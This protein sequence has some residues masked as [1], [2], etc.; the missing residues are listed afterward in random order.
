[1]SRPCRSERGNF[2]VESSHIEQSTLANRFFD[3]LQ[4]SINC[5]QAQFLGCAMK[6]YEDNNQRLPE[7]NVTAWDRS[8]QRLH[9]GAILF[10]ACAIAAGPPV[11]AQDA[12]EAA[13]QV[14]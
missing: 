5:L 14:R 6:K 1:M 11:W 10:A 7:F 3:A 9:A 12:A 8:R 13:G 2:G 4:P